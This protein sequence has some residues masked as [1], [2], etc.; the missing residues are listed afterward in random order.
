MAAIIAKVKSRGGRGLTKGGGGG[1]SQLEVLV[2]NGKTSPKAL[3][4]R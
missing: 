1:G 3:K 2:S 4:E